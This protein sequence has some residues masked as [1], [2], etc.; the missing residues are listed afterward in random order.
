MSAVKQIVAAG[1]DVTRLNRVL[2]SL[3][4]RIHGPY[5]R[6]LNYHGV[7]EE[8]AEAFE[9]Q[10]RLFA[11]QFVFAGYDDLLALQAGRWSHD[12]PGLLITFDDGLRSHAE[13]AAPILEEWGAV[14]WFMVPA[15]VVQGAPDGKSHTH[16]VEQETL[17]WDGL[18][19]LDERH[20][21]GCHTFSHRRLEAS[22]TPEELE[23]EIGAAKRQLE[24]WLGHE[25][26][27]FAWVG[28]EEWAYSTEAARAIRDAGFEISFMTNS[29]V[30]R[31]G[32]DLLQLQRTHT[33][34]WF[35]PEVVRLGLSGV[36]DWVYASKRKRVNRLTAAS[37]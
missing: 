2:L 29:A 37:D 4:R 30:I 11:E 24:S 8:Q 13:I 6:A 25:V 1:F 14:G 15:G 35:T 28:G 22:L 9:A 33:E 10:L 21:V 23:W 7:T 26:K 27:T 12:K 19:R 32:A 36:I 17:S 31:P 5:I 34:A 20:I 3:Q 16:S 18:R